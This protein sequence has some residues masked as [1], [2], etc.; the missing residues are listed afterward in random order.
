[1]SFNKATPCHILYCE[2]ENEPLILN[3]VDAQPLL[4]AKYTKA[5]SYALKQFTDEERQHIRFVNVR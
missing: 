2:D 1:M 5:K 3:G 4:F